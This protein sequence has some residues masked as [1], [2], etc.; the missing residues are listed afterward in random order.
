MAPDDGTAQKIFT[1]KGGEYLMC[2]TCGCETPRPKK[3]EKKPQK[4]R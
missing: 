2:A 4:V 1:M 3:E